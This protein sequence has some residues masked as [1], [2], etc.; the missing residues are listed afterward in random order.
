MPPENNNDQLVVDDIYSPETTFD[1]RSNAGETRL[2][3]NTIIKQFPDGSAAI[4]MMDEDQEAPQVPIDDHNAN[5]AEFLN[6]QDLKDI[7]GSISEMIE[8]D[9]QSQEQFFQA[10]AKTIEY[11]G[12]D[13]SSNQAGDDLPFK[14]A[15]SVYSAAMFESALDIVTNAKTAIYPSTNMVDTVILGEAAQELQDIA[16]RMKTYF[17]YYFDDVAKEFRKEAMRA[18]FWAVISGSVYKKVYI[19]PV[20]GRPVSQFIPIEDFIVNRS[21][22][23]HLSASRRTHILHI[24]ERE[25]KMR[26]SSGM[27]R[28]VSIMK[29]DNYGYEDSEIQQQLDQISGFE[30]TSDLQ[31]DSGY[32]IYECHIDYYIK[33]DPMCSPRKISLPYVISIDKESSKV[34]SIR[35]NWDENNELKQK[36]EYFVNYSMLPSLDGE[37]YGLTN[38]ATRLAEAAT[39]ME[40]QLINA[41]IFS[42]FPGGVYQSGMRLENN[43]LRPAPGEFVPLATGGTPLNQAVMPFRYGDTSAVLLELKNGIEDSIR[44]P[45]AIINQKIMDLPSRAPQGTVLAIIEN[46]HRLPNALMQ[47]WHESFALELELFRDRFADWFGDEPYPFMVPGGQHVIMKSDFQTDI[48]VRPSSDPSQK[49]SAYRFMLSE[50]VVNHAKEMPQLFNT[51]FAFQYYL[52]NLGVPEDDIKQLLS[53]P[54]TPP[55]P[56][57]DPISTMMAVMQGKPVAAAPWQDHDAYISIIDSWMQMNPQNPAVPAAQALKTQHEALKYMV[58]TYA[59]LGMQPPEDP[60]QVPPEMQNQMAIAVAQMKQ[61]EAQQA[62]AQ[63]GVPAE[64]P[65]DPAKVQLEDVHLRA[66]MTHEQHEIDIM[67]IEMEQKKYDME[68]SL[69]ERELSVETQ[70]KA[71]KQN[72]EEQKLELSFMK[73]H[74][75]QELKERDQSLKERDNMLNKFENDVN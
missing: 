62:A 55:P 69:K 25:Y 2:S 72:I 61:Q 75:E 22:S 43:N 52:K 11:L 58:N 5:L 44:K 49:N 53:P 13:L 18:M 42:N 23:S 30:H 1:P 67:R 57:L 26:V 24:N 38:Y 59:Q 41:A 40:R 6:E 34:L 10:N 64:P 39:S 19:C 71:L 32:T 21:Y 12:L 46:L 33:Q 9:I 20:L 15:A 56:P 8:N 29:D 47:G 37:G 31:G 28:D 4:G 60:S 73:Q 50:I 66:Q 48:K 17:N 16:Y 36:K 14:G 7:A 54:E 63:S 45:S 3:D 27:Y 65:L 74:H 70:I 68:F 35:R 51:K